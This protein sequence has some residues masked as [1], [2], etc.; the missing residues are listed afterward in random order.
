MSFL[1]KELKEVC[2]T[3]NCANEH[4]TSPITAINTKEISYLI[5]RNTKT[6]SKSLIKTN[7]ISCGSYLTKIFSNVQVIL[8]YMLNI[9][10]EQ[11]EDQDRE[12][13][14]S[15]QNKL[16]SFNR[17]E[18]DKKFQ[19]NQQ[20]NKL[21]HNKQKETYSNSPNRINFYYKIS[22]NAVKIANRHSN[23]QS[24]ENVVVLG[25]FE[26][27]QRGNWC[28]KILSHLNF[29]HFNC[30]PQKK[31]IQ[32][33][34]NI[35]FR[36]NEIIKRTVPFIQTIRPIDFKIFTILN[37]LNCNFQFKNIN[38]F[39]LL[40]SP[41]SNNYEENLENSKMESK[42]NVVI[43]TDDINYV[44]YIAKAI[45]KVHIF[46]SL[47]SYSKYSQYFKETL[48]ILDFN[49]KPKSSE[50][51]DLEFVIK[52]SKHSFPEYSYHRLSP[53]EM[54]SYNVRLTD[55]EIAQ[56]NCIFTNQRQFL[57]GVVEPYKLLKRIE[58]VAL[59]L[60]SLIGD[61]SA[62]SV[63]EEYFVETMFI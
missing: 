59:S 29:T 19:D 12:F 55:D 7:C 57:K 60:K 61:S 39:N 16:K 37:I 1:K 62:L 40:S 4:C 13:K 47:K 20:M 42:K 9:L 5:D 26:R 52:T 45:T 18:Q 38:E 14:D 32:K 27:N 56:I 50:Q 6:I 46:Y 53:T 10:D 58:G 33:N 43:Y 24:F 8:F 48:C 49:D 44:A 21:H 31:T 11:N 35:P 22:I 25:H 2:I 51:K 23:D 63:I 54:K 30:E 15:E 3:F 41:V 17:N 28:F 36:L 34:I